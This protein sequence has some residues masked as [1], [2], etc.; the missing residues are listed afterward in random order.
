MK[1]IEVKTS[2]LTGAALDWAVAEAEGLKPSKNWT[3]IYY[4]PS[5]DWSVTGPLIDRYSIWLSNDDRGYIASIPLHSVIAGAY[6]GD[7]NACLPGGG[8]AL[9]AVC[10][11]IVL[12]KIGTTVEVPEQLLEVKL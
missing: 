8:T 9:V 3:G 5:T 7:I 6:T 10:R 12:S 11:A 4:R 2:E 1:T